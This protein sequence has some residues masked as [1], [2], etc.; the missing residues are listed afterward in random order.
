MIHGFGNT[1]K[2][3]ADTNAAREKHEKPSD[4][5]V[6]GNVVIFAKLDVRV[7]GEVEPNEED[8]PNILRSDIK[9][10]EDISHPRLAKEKTE[11]AFEKLRRER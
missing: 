9:P 1:I 4:V 10:S 8:G 3:K 7:F 6:F 2:E 11:T 5:I